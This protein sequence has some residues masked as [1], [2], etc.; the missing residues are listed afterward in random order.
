MWLFAW[1]LLSPFVSLSFI[2][3]CWDRKLQAWRRNL[4]SFLSKEWL[5][6]LSSH[7]SFDLLQNLGKLSKSFLALLLIGIFLVALVSR[8]KIKWLWAP[9]FV[10]WFCPE[11]GSLGLDWIDWIL[12][13]HL[14]FTNSVNKILTVS[15]SHTVMWPMVNKN[16]N[17]DHGI[18]ANVLWEILKS[19]F[20]LHMWKRRVPWL[21]QDRLMVIQG[22]NAFS[23]WFVFWSLE[24]KS[25]SVNLQK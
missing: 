16:K 20:D 7:F 24:D 1:E 10:T 6:P 15:H 8:E 11:H 3:L 14:K 13:R 22:K 5:W 17:S 23:V 9:H 4:V 2:F 25:H 18:F 19:D 12:W 21:S